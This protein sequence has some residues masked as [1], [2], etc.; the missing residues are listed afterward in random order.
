VE[1]AGAAGGAQTGADA[2]GVRIRRDAAV[3]CW[4]LRSQGEGQAGLEA[5]LQDLYRRGLEADR[6]A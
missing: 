1:L 4:L 2:G 3:T 5:L 6:W